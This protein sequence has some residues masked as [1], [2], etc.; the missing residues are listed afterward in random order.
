M[1]LLLLIR[2]VHEVVAPDIFRDVQCFFEAELELYI[3][4]CICTFPLRNTFNLYMTYDQISSSYG[5]NRQH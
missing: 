3:Q 4:M 2:V 5:S 1:I